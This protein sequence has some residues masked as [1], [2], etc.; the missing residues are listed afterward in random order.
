MWPGALV[1][2]TELSRSCLPTDSRS[3]FLVQTFSVLNVQRHRLSNDV[4][5]TTFLPLVRGLR[6]RRG[7][8][9]RSFDE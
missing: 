5:Q 8:F 9:V 3:S 2:K 6:S 7:V 4:L 1:P